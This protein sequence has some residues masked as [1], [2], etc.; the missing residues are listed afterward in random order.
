MPKITIDEIGSDK[1]IVRDMTKAELD[2]IAI[3]PL[4]VEK[5]R[6]LEEAKKA[7]RQELLAKLGITE[8]E[9]RLLLGGN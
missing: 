1:K 7:A 4:E 3:I 5:E 9:A 8:E 6:Q 2:A